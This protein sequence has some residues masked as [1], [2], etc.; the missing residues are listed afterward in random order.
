MAL[1]A[2]LPTQVRFG[3][4]VRGFIPDGLRSRPVR[5]LWGKGAL[6]TLSG[7]N[8]LATGSVCLEG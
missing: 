8:P 7:I 4:V 1:A 3:S 5:F 6:R 2:E